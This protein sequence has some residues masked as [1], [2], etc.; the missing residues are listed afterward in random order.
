[1]LQHGR[2]HDGGPRGPQ[3]PRLVIREGRVCVHLPFH[4]NVCT[5]T[6]GSPT[7]C[8]ACARRRRLENVRAHTG[9][10][11]RLST[12]AG[13]GRFSV[14]I[15]RTA[16]GG[17]G[18]RRCAEHEHSGGA[19]SDGPG[20]RACITLTRTSSTCANPAENCT[21]SAVRDN[22]EDAQCR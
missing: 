18:P 10:C 21:L 1:M 16:H 6:L 20:Q 7:G 5:N 4:S 2:V 19:H 17:P 13:A 12:R 3:D 9:R 8:I 15:P 14:C 11:V 22:R